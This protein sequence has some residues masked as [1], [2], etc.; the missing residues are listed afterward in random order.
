MGFQPLPKTLESAPTP[1]AIMVVCHSTKTVHRNC[2]VRF[3]DGS[4]VD[5]N[6]RKVLWWRLKCGVALSQ[7]R[8]GPCRSARYKLRV[9]NSFPF[10]HDLET[11]VNLNLIYNT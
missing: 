10:S 11:G 6:L 5:I 9:S 8:L 4:A 7:H 1:S 3:H 2:I